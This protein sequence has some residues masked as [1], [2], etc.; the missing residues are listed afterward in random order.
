[1]IYVCKEFFGTAHL[2]LVHTFLIPLVSLGFEDF[3][4]KIWGSRPLRNPIK[5]IISP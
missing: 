2:C 5:A 4:N 3:Q 1:M